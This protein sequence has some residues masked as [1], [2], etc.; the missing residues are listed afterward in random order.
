LADDVMCPV[1]IEDFVW[2]GARV[3]IL[4]GVRIGEG[5][6]VQMGAVV[7]KD[8]PPYAVVGGSPAKIL[9]YRDQARFEQL[10]ANGK[11]G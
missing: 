5:A 10:K 2:L 9:K 3:T 7:T 8:V 11:F 1:V 6:I 4:P